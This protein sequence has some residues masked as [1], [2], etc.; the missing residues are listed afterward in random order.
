MVF[1]VRYSMKE[2]DDTVE[3][4]VREMSFNNIILL[5]VNLSETDNTSVY[6]P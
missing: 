3:V 1:R 2:G 4:G 5:K 6:E